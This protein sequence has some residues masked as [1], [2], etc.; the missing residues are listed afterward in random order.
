MLMQPL[1][2]DQ[3]WTTFILSNLLENWSASRRS[4]VAPLPVL[5]ELAPK[6]GIPSELIVAFC[7]V[8]E[9]AE[10]CLGRS[11]NVE[12][13]CS[14]T[15]QRP[16]HALIEM[17]QTGSATE[18]AASFAEAPIELWKALLLASTNVSRLLAPQEHELDRLWDTVHVARLIH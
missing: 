16:E 12:H 10:A 4:G 9:L 3:K 2:A 8:F 14:D 11:L 17:L 18:G 5:I 7:S 6:L 15:L 13:C 1:K